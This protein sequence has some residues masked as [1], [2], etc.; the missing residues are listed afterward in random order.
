MEK[1]QPSVL[2]Y[3]GLGVGTLSNGLPFNFPTHLFS[4][5]TLVCGQTGTGKSRFAM[6]LA[7]KAENN[8]STHRIKL[9]IIAVDVILIPVCL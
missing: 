5:H 1:K 4:T 3:W 8:F 9:L 2:D 6:N 7:V